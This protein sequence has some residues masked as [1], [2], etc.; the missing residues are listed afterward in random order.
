MAIHNHKKCVP[1]L[2]QKK[3]KIETTEFKEENFLSSASETDKK[4]DLESEKQLSEKE[5]SALKERYFG[6]KE[7]SEI[8]QILSTSE[9]NTRKI[10]SRGLKKLRL[11]YQGENN[12]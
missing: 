10:I 11:K 9:S 12:G 5:R 1:R 3:N 6:D 2:Y 8:A 4:L 7:F